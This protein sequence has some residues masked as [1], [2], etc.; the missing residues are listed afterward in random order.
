MEIE[1]IFFFST[2]ETVPT[3]I[4]CPREALSVVAHQCHETGDKLVP[5]RM[6]TGTTGGVV[7]VVPLHQNL[8][9]KVHLFF[10]PDLLINHF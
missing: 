4:L 7:D 8:D 6:S 9:Y 1:K 3:Y 10:L 5:L 2:L